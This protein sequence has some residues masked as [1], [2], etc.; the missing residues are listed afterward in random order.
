MMHWTVTVEIERCGWSL[1]VELTG[2]TEK[3]MEL[4]MTSGLL[5]WVMEWM[6]VLSIEVMK[7]GEDE[8]REMEKVVGV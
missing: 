4:R 8:M 2:L 6:V 7:R 1:E 3:G 5:A